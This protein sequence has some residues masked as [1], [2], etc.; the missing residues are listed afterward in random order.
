LRSLYFECDVQ[1][2]I[3][4]LG[5]VRLVPFASHGLVDTRVNQMAGKLYTLTSGNDRLL[6]GVQSV[7]GSRTA[8]HIAI[9]GSPTLYQGRGQCHFLAWALQLRR[10]IEQPRSALSS[11]SSA[12][13]RA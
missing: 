6:I 11:A 1:A 2:A 8:L 3:A 9:S 10:A 4:A 12:A 13:G 7:S 5:S